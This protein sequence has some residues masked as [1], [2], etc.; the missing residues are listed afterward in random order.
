MC[1]MK[2]EIIGAKWKYITCEAFWI[3]RLVVGIIGNIFQTHLVRIQIGW[4]DEILWMKTFVNLFWFCCVSALLGIN[5]DMT[6]MNAYRA[7]FVQPKILDASYFILIKSINTSY[8]IILVGCYC[9]YYNVIFISNRQWQ[10][11]N[12]HS[13]SFI[14]IHMKN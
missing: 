8:N 4:L 10:Q 3:R 5:N 2:T 13:S 9:F 12:I 14:L 6:E 7:H 11:H 1:G